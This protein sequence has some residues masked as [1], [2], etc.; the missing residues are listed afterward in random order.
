MNLFRAL[1]NQGHTIDETKEII[2]EMIEDLINGAQ[3][4]EILLDYGLEEDYILDLINY[5]IFG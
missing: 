2:A 4:D 5:A 1:I 3:P